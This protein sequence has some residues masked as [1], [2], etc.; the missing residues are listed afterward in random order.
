M[1]GRLVVSRDWRSDE[2]G[3]GAATGGSLGRPHSYGAGHRNA[4][5]NKLVTTKYTHHTHIHSKTGE[6]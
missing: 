5:S 3:R 1:E 2:G 4:H 6:I